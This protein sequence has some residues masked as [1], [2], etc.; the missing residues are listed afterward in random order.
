M[1][2]LAFWRSIR[3]GE[4]GPAVAIS[5]DGAAQ[6]GGGGKRPAKAVCD[7]MGN[8]D[9][10]KLQVRWWGMFLAAAVCSGLESDVALSDDGLLRA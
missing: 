6:A 7:A 1:W 4:A 8:E 10:L 5:G 2:A 3:W 9:L